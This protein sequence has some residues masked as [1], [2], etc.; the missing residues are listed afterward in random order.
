[1]SLPVMI[2]LACLVRRAAP[3]RVARYQYRNVLIP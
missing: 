2:L 1:M 3:V